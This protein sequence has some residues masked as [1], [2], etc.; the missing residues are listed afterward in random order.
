MLDLISRSPVSSVGPRTNAEKKA[1]YKA[2]EDAV[3]SLDSLSNEPFDFTYPRGL[4]AEAA[5]TRWHQAARVVKDLTLPMP[6]PVPIFS[7]WVCVTARI[8]GYAKGGFLVFYIF[9]YLILYEST[10]PLFSNENQQLRPTRHKATQ[11]PIPQSITMND[12]S[13]QTSSRCFEVVSAFFTSSRV[14]TAAA[15]GMLLPSSPFMKIKSN[16][17]NVLRAVSG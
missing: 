8:Q 1:I 14:S 11:Y 7:P 5:K 9:K 3:S 15:T 10:S 16:S 17:S 2:N 4:G 13:T 6:I 12:D